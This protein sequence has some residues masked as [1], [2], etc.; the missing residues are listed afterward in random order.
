MEHDVTLENFVTKYSLDKK[1]IENIVQA[2]KYLP[3]ID[4]FQCFKPWGLLVILCIS[5]FSA[6]PSSVGPAALFSQCYLVVL[7][8]SLKNLREGWSGKEI[9]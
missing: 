9:S 4:I 7:L 5:V 6:Q 1:P 8:E 2:F 3:T